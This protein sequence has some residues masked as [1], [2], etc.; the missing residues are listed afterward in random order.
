MTMEGNTLYSA[1]GT[2]PPPSFFQVRK[3]FL[4]SW[5]HSYHRR[6]RAADVGVGEEVSLELPLFKQ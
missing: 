4:V 5:F 3:S 1:V 6:R 2:A